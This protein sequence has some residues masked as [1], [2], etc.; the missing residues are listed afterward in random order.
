MVSEISLAFTCSFYILQ[1]TVKYSYRATRT[2]KLAGGKVQVS[3]SVVLTE[4]ELFSSEAG[5][6]IVAKKSV[7]IVYTAV[8]Q[9]NERK[10][11]TD[12]WV[13]TIFVER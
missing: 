4:A 8:N 11:T 3:Q 7:I 1:S 5:S 2:R 10:G 6:V 13:S 9:Y 12:V